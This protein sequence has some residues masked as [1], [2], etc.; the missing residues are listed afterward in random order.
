MY[1]LPNTSGVFAQLNSLRVS[2]TANL[3]REQ[4]LILT[5]YFS[6]WFH[7]KYF[8]PPDKCDAS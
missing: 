8:S 5:F 6:L 7:I 1:A 3:K 4:T 2:K